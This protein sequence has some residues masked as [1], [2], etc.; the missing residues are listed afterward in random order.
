[1]QMWIISTVA[2][3]LTAGTDP[4]ASGQR[5]LESNGRT[6]KAE[7]F[8]H[9]EKGARWIE[10]AP[11]HKQPGFDEH[12][13]YWQEQS[14]SG[15][16]VMQGVF[17]DNA[18][19]AMVIVRTTSPVEARE[20]V[21]GDPWVE[22]GVVRAVS[23]RPWIPPIGGELARTDHAWTHA[24]PSSRVL[25]KEV[26]VRATPKDVWDCWTTSKGIA[27]FFTPESRVELRVGGP[28]ELYMMSEP[29]A[30]G[31]GS[32]GCKVLS[33]VPYEM[34]SF[35][36]SFPPKVP[37]LR[38]SRAKTHVVLRFE[39]K[40]DGTTSVRFDQLGWR[41]GEDW[42]QGFAYFDAAWDMVLQNLKKRFQGDG[43]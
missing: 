7:Y 41:E 8:C 23:P 26:T 38:F 2:L 13:A 4:G 15:V 14:D 12:K 35:E 30:V 25:S 22:T 27:S 16:L 10:D 9:L 20:I 19:G 36:W 40:G 18:G 24:S 31:R 5:Q 32:E 28:Y 39:D 29:D 43:G 11:A 1:M 33:Y 21:A 34:L 3:T 6:P 42:D 17:A 37:T